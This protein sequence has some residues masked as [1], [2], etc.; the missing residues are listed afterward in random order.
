MEI[1]GFGFFPSV[2]EPT[3]PL[4]SQC[5]RNVILLKTQIVIVITIVY[6]YYFFRLTNRTVVSVNKAVYNRIC[7]YCCTS[8]YTCVKTS[9]LRLPGRLLI[10]VF[11]LTSNRNKEQT[12]LKTNLKHTVLNLNADLTHVYIF[13]SAP[14]FNK[15][16]GVRV[17]AR[18]GE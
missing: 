11:N 7:I 4:P 9:S 10:R 1:G 3:F 16:N 2:S 5:R 12:H 15:T 17:V 8:V 18:G 13:C 6:Y 14:I